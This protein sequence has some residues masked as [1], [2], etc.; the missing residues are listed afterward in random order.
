MTDQSVETQIALIQADMAT[1]TKAVAKQS[2]DI[3]GLVQAWKTA[4]GVVSFMKWL[5]S[6]AVAVS[7]LFSVI[8]LKLFGAH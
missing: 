1:L 8:K 5:S 2:S 7:I 4:N 6:I 3:E